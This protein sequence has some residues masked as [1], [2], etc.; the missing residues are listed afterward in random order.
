MNKAFEQIKVGL[1]DAIDYQKN[2][3]DIYPGDK[4]IF[5]FP[6]SASVSSQNQASKYL[7]VNREYKVKG[8][9]FKSTSTEIFLSEF[10]NISFDQ[11]MFLKV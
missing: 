8:L 3:S 1:Q 5:C 9:V 11:K 2:S 7:K 4:V 10:P 6:K